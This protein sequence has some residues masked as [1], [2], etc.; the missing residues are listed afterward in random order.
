MT[1]GARLGLLFG[2]R[3]VEHEISVVSARGVAAALK[4]T[5]FVTIPL[6]VTGD[7]RWL[8]PALSQSI[9]ASGSSRVEPAA[10]ED[11]GVNL[12]IDPGGRGL[13]LQ[14]P[15]KPARPLELYYRPTNLRQQD[16]IY[17]YINA[18]SLESLVETLIQRARDA[19][20]KRMFRSVDR[21]ELMT[22]VDPAVI[23]R[24]VEEMAAE[25]G[26]LEDTVGDAVKN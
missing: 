6:G 25:K 3:S 16:A 1:A 23:E 19:D 12:L 7:G 15:G 21:R 11:D 26:T 20:G 2:G 5:G 14:E 17:K 8:S 18:G 24:V 22:E 13:L 9:L 10:G 4:E